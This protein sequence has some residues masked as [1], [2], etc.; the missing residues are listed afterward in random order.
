MGKTPHQI[1][2]EYYGYDSFRGEQE[3]IIENVI[4]RNDVVVLMPTGGGKSICFQI[5]ALYL[6]GMC[7]VVSPLIAL[8]KDQVE[9][10]KRN[11]IEAAFLNSS[12]SESEQ[13]VVEN[14]I[15]DGKLK[16]LYVSPEKLLS[17]SFL[18]YL[19]KLNISFF[20]IDEAHCISQWGHDFRPEYTQLKILKEK[21]PQKNIIALT[22]TADKP[23]RLDIQNQLAL[24]NPKVFIASFNRPNLSLT[25]KPGQNKFG[26]LITFLINRKN[27]AG[28][29][30]CLSRKSTETV[31]LKLREQGYKAAHYHAGMSSSERSEVQEKFLRDEYLIICATIAF[32][33]GIDKPNVRWVVHYNLPKNIEGYYQEIGRAGRDGLPSDTL[34]FYSIADILTLQEFLSTDNPVFRELQSAKLE[35]M[36]NYA[37]ANIC[38]R[39]IL[40]SYFGETV[41]KNCGNCDVCKN[42]RK[43]FDGTIIA[44][45]AL[46]AI[47]RTNEEISLTSLIDVLRG[48]KSELI[49]KRNYFNIKT[50]GA[51][52]DL[53][54]DDWYDYLLQLLHLGYFEIAYH[55]FNNLKL[56]NLSREVLFNNKKVELVDRKAAQLLKIE[57]AT[58]KYQAT[59]DL[60]ERLREL[61]KEIA[62]NENVPAYLIFNDKTLNEMA[63]YKPTTKEDMLSISG[64]GYHKFD[65]Y[66]YDFLDEINSFIL[67]KNKRKAKVK[68]E[69]FNETLKLY[70]EGFTIE[71]ISE[72]RKLSVSTIE[73]HIIKLYEINSNINFADFITQSE[74]QKVLS[75]IRSVGLENGLKPLYEKLEEKVSYF[76]IKIGI[77]YYNRFVGK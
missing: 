68:G 54:L 14:Y 6:E 62:E 27:Q 51:G 2:K 47:A 26:Q 76:K 71:E 4:S 66:G 5:P 61:R 77:I 73:S 43:K 20:A 69:T 1:L 40:L 36:K 45:K 21:F 65:L 41:T 52:K 37:E 35:R 17:A 74:L 49:I 60:F 11:G 48:V 15:N 70:K 53:S 9:G 46:S 16:L 57:E 19:L 67:E 34:L 59:N 29:V 50:F 3:E 24:E 13:R 18:N 56:T 12:L 23:T 33:M 75:A 28:I 32:G 22:A 25:V 30:Y 44:Q 7:V 72:K 58:P 31:A 42:P 64:V 8:M 55:N 63:Q 38:R 10:L 39:I